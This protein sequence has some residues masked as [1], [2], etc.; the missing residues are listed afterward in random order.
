[1]RISDLKD[2]IQDSVSIYKDT[3]SVK[4]ELIYSGVLKEA[5]VRVLGMFIG[6]ITV[7]HNEIHILVYELPFN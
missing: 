4:L 1:M 2:L 7:G 6:N 3:G 5:P